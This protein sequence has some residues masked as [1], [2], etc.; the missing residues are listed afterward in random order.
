MNSTQDKRSVCVCVFWFWFA[1]VSVCSNV[2][3]LLV[4]VPALLVRMIV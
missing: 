3:W 1:C 4:W 2:L